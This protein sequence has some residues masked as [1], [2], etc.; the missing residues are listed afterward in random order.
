MN[1]SKR[2]SSLHSLDASVEARAAHLRN[3]LRQE[4]TQALLDRLET[5][6]ETEAIDDIELLSAILDVLDEKAP[7]PESDKDPAEGLA[8]LKAAYAP[9]F[10]ADD[11][12]SVRKADRSPKAFRNVLKYAAVVAVICGSLLTGM[13]G[14]QAAGFNIFGSLAQWTEDTFHFITGSRQ[15]VSPYYETFRQALEGADMP[16]EL[17]PTWYPKGFE[18]TETKVWSDKLGSTVY[19]FFE[20]PGGSTFDISIEFYKE[21]RYIEAGTYEKND[22]KIEPYTS[23]SRTF[24]IFDNID[25]V[26]ATWS[27]GAYTERISGNLSVADM[28]K[29]INSIG[30]SKHD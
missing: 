24:Y 7:L 27:D 28:K 4:N 1:K 19:M 25:I 11:K 10:E 9:V 16:G 2:G 20:K 29:I 23:N 6:V 17:A 18:A 22:T 12:E 21:P 8:R 5:M 15:E 13:I 30:V 26:I 3:E 14:I